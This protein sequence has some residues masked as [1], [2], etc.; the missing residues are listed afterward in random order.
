M[1]G[2]MQWELIE[3][4]DEESIYARFLAEKGGGVHHIAVAAQ[5]FDETLDMNAKRGNDVVLSGEFEG[6][7][8]AYLGMDRDLG[9]IL[10]ISKG[11]PKLERKPEAI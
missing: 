10:E 3:P 8:V 1:V 2:R 9:V 4:L 7:K 5:N 6:F 11:M